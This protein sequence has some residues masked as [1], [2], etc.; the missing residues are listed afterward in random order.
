VGRSDPD[1]ENYLSGIYIPIMLCPTSTFPRPYR[2]PT[3]ARW[4]TSGETVRAGH[5]GEIT[6]DWFDIPTACTAFVGYHSNQVS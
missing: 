3:Q 6:S 1:L 4:A 2:K 5:G